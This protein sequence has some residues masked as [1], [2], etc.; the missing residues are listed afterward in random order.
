M[1]TFRRQFAPDIPTTTRTCINCNLKFVRNHGDNVLVL[2]TAEWS[3]KAPCIINYDTRSRSSTQYVFFI[4]GEWGLNICS[5]KIVVKWTWNIS[6]V[7][8][9]SRYEELLNLSQ[10]ILRFSKFIIPLTVG[11]HK[12][13][14]PLLLYFNCQAESFSFEQIYPNIILLN[15]KKPSKIPL[16]SWCFELQ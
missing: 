5:N 12:T 2:R 8:V 6:D 1:P 4:P 9:I 3:R 15:P 11:S 14:N 10:N 7:N 16:H 13:N